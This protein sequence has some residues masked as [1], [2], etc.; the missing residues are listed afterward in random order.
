MNRTFLSKTVC[1]VLFDLIERETK[2]FRSK[3]FLLFF[4][5]SARFLLVCSW[6][7]VGQTLTREFSFS[8]YFVRAGLL[9]NDDDE[10]NV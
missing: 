5:N 9:F 8:E 7:N 1:F 2:E 10:E 4:V 3:I 6:P